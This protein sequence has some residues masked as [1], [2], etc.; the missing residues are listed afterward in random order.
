M[1][2]VARHRIERS[3][4]ELLDAAALCAVSTVSPRAAAHVATVYFAWNREFEIVWLSAITSV[5]SRNIDARAG[6]AIA[7]YDSGQVWGDP[8]RGI[9]LF[10]S[11]R[12]L[13]AAEAASAAALYAARFEG[14]APTDLPAYRVYG[15]RAERL[16]VF[17]EPVFGPGVFVT[18]V[19]RDDDRRLVWERTDVLS[20]A[21]A[22]ATRRGGRR[23]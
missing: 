18:A 12:R 16:T 22:G 21:A 10:G 3:A 8:D 17:D 1:R 14:Y 13:A 15:F 20:G 4:F 23:R 6:A 7:V 11:A 5:H 2:P 9:Q 19:V